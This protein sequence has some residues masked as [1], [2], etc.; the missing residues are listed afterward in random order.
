MPIDQSRYKGPRVYVVEPTKGEWSGNNNLGANRDFDP[1]ANNRQDVLFMPE[2]GPPRR[3]T[4][5]LGVQYSASLASRFEVVAE[6]EVG[7]GGVTQTFQVDW[8]VGQSITVNANSIKVTAIWF[9]PHSAAIKLQCTV[10]RGES[11]CAHP[12]IKCANFGATVTNGNDSTIVAIP[13]F[14]RRVRLCP[15][16]SSHAA[17]YSPASFIQFLDDAAGVNAA[18]VVF[19]SEMGGAAYAQGAPIPQLAKFV[20]Y[21]NGSGSDQAGT[22]IF[23]IEP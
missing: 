4:I 23:D 15:A 20:R 12:P 14:A 19:G 8:I 6:I 18:G 21:H 9:V 17:I 16:N 22:W 11:G 1:T 5:T 13:A 7:V 2:W 10:A 3:W